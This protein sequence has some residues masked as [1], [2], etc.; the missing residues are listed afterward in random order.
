VS[1]FKSPKWGL[2]L[3]A[4]WLILSGV[5]AFVSSLAGMNFVLAI[6]AIVAGVL[7]LMDR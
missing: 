2:R 7:M 1:W 3:A 6:L 4:V 5:S